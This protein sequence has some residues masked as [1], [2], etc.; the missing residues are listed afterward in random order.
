MNRTAKFL[1]LVVLFAAIIGMTETGWTDDEIPSPFIGVL[2]PAVHPDSAGPVDMTFS[3]A[4]TEHCPT[5]NDVT[6][7]VITEKGLKYLG[8][9]SWT[10]HVDTAN[11]YSTVLHIILPP[12]DTSCLRVRMQSGRISVTDYACFVTTDDSVEFWKGYP[13]RSYWD[14]PIPEPDTTRYEVRIDLRNPRHYEHIMKH[15]DIVGPIEVTA[16]SGF[17]IIHVTRQQFDGMKRERFKCEYLEEPPPRKPGQPGGGTFKRIRPAPDSS[18]DR[19]IHKSGWTDDV[20]PMPFT[21][22]LEPVVHPDS[23]G[24]VD[25]TFSFAPTEHCRDCDEVTM[26]VITKNGLKHLGPESW[27]VHVDSASPY[28]TVLH[29]ILPPDDTSSLRIRIQSGGLFATAYAY[30]VTT[31]DSVEFWKGYPEGRYWDIPSPEPDTTKYEVRIDLRNPVRYEFI[32]KHEDEVAPIEPT[33]DSGFYIIHITRE[34]FD[35]LKRDNYRCD[36]LKEPPPRKPG[37]PGVKIKTFKRSEPAPD[38]SRNRTP[39]QKTGGE[40]WLDC[41]DGEDEWGRLYANTL[42]RFILGFANHYDDVVHGIVNGFRI[43]SPNGATWD[44]TYWDT[45]GTLA[46]LES[47]DLLFGVYGRSATGSGADSIKFVGITQ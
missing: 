22:V 34:Q 32:K 27:T 15:K 37:R 4:P 36:Y 6:I 31:G 29:I 44:S 45:L 9:E 30:F 39:R 41:V 40:I 42:I 2:K 33:A 47:F 17:Y 13:E 5:C 16:D 35:D 19:R 24:P 7:T 20:V 14:I 11:P 43:Y 3:F 23:A 46:W 12:D 28:S 38:S 10:V 18:Q 26:T 21:C 25:M 8:P 1:G